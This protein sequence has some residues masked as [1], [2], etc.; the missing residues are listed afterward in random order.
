MPLS[1]LHSARNAADCD[2]DNSSDRQQGV[3]LEYPALALA[4]LLDQV[5]A[6]PSVQRQLTDTIKDYEQNLLKQ[7]TWKP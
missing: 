4:E 7:S 2:L 1:I 3:N 6:T 5:R